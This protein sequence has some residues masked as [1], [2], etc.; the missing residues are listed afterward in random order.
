MY[1]SVS[2]LD[3]IACFLLGA[4]ACFSDVVLMILLRRVGASVFVTL[5]VALGIWERRERINV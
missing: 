4:T 2:V 5:R 1:G 3:S